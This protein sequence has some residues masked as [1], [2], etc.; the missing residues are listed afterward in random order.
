MRGPAMLRAETSWKAFGFW[1]AG[2]FLGAAAALY[3]FVLVMDPY[4]VSPFAAR[5]T[6]PMLDTNQRYMYPQ[7]I[8]ARQHD[9]LVI[10]TSTSRLLEPARLDAAFGGRFANLALSDGRAWEQYR[11]T[12]L[13][14]RESGAPKVLFVGIDKVWCDVDADTARITSRGFP[15]WMYDDDPWNDL[16]GIFNSR[17]L[18]IALRRFGLMLGIEELR[19]DADGFGDFT[20][21]EAAYDAARADEHI[22]GNRARTIAP[23]NPPVTPTAEQRA[24]WRFPALGWLEEILART[25]GKSRVM[26]VFMPVHVVMQPQPGSL[27]AAREAECKRLVGELAERYGADVHDFR[28]PSEVTTTDTNWWDPLHWR[29]G[30]GRDLIDRLAAR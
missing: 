11:I 16:A 15:E 26:L 28:V 10:G 12:D 4:G 18:V 21:G 19:F 13:F 30:I 20:P 8:R 7:L 3:V 23:A 14:I 2:G 29:I 22:W 9:S 1:L 27:E 24:A 25:R 5:T 6:R 17:T